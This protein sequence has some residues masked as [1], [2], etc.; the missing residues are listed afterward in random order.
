MGAMP[1][2]AAV[3]YDAVQGFSLSNPSTVW[4]Y[5]YAG[6]PFAISESTPNGLGVPY[7]WTGG[8]VPV[9]GIIG[10]NVSGSTVAVETIVDPNNTL[11]LDP[12]SLSNVAV[13]FTA[14]AAGK[15]TITG[16]FL[17]IDTGERSH[18]V[19]VLNGV[20]PIFSD[21]I[22]AFGA[23]DSFSDTVTLTKDGTI[24][25]LVEG[26][27]LA[28]C[29]Y[30]NLSTGLTAQISSAVPEPATW[31]MMLFGFGSLGGMMRSRR[32]QTLATA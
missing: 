4:S 1:G 23:T 10:Q 17:G 31:A 13:T 19:E 14:P 30:C 26:G 25:F 32:K 20:T 27:S 6:A 11:W 7:W 29:G 16:S 2:H 5:S 3:T 8:N 18:G 15:Y 9:S 21:T 22:G 12:E 28:D 24:S